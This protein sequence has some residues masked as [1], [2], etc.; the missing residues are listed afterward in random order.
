MFVIYYIESTV[1]SVKVIILFNT[2]KQHCLHIGYILTACCNTNM[3]DYRLF[4][5]IFSHI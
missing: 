5:H 4:L 1:V 2:G 3:E